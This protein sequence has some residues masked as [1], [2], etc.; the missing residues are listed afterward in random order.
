MG[1]SVHRSKQCLTLAPWAVM[2][3]LQRF[4][5]GFGEHKLEREKMP[6]IIPGYISFLF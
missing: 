3:K 1:F 4:F 6:Q 2:P 5:F